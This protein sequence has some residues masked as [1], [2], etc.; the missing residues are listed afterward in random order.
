MNTKQLIEKII[1]KKEFSQLPI[2]DVELVFEKFDKKEFL[3][4][5]KIKLSRDLLRK[6]Y[7]AFVSP[8]LLNIKNNNE[9]WFLKKHIS[10]KERFDFYEKIYKKLLKGF[11]NKLTVF[12]LGAGVNGFSYNYFKNNNLNYI[13]VEAV[14]QLVNLMNNYFE[15]NKLKARAV[16]ESLFELEKIKKIVVKENGDKVVFL[17]KTL[18]SLEMLERD[19]S[20]KLLEEIV[21]LVDKVVVSFA[22]RSLVSKRKFNVQRNWIINFIKY[23]FQILEDFELGTERYISFR[24]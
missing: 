13:A 8:K 7:T 2:K 3:D 20:K 4:E 14:G 19:Y 21:P 24:G 9:E 17:F 5:E 16:H 23:N 15:K 6:I 18:D 11:N 1:E 22:T 10:T 12:D